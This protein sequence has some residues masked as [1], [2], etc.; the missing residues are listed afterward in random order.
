MSIGVDLEKELLTNMQ[1]LTTAEQDAIRIFSAMYV[2]SYENIKLTKIQSLENSIAEQIKFYGKKKDDYSASIQ[3]I[4]DSYTQNIDF[5]IKQYN[6]YFCAILNDLQETQN[7]QKIA[8]MNEKM[9]I[10]SKDETKRIAVEQKIMNYEIVLGEC[11]RQL[12]Q[13]KMQMESKLNEIFYEKDK[14]LSTGKV[15]VFQKIMNIFSG[16][17]KVENFVIHSLSVEMNELSTK[18]NEEVEKLADEM[19]KN[20]AIIK[21]AMMQTQENFSNMLEG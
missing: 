14:Q 7:N 21:D 13:C 2:N 9:C 16:K 18:V 8:F 3:P 19:I 4:I 12:E 6:T 10:S 1:D 11:R 15:S 5:I 17:S 20:I